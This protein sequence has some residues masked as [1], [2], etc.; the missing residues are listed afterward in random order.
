MNN[1]ILKSY[2][3]SLKI[4]KNLSSN[5]I[6]SYSI[7][8]NNFFEYVN[9]VYTKITLE[10]INNYIIHLSKKGL[11]NSSINHNITSLKMFYKYLIKEGITNTN[12]IDKVARPKKEA[13]LPDYLTIDEINMLLSFKL[14]NAYD[15]RNKALLE[16]MYATGVRVSEVINVKIS[17]IDFYED[18]IT[19]IGKGNKERIIPLTSIAL[20]SIRVYLDEYY[21]D[22]LKS[23]KSEYLFINKSGGRLTRQGVVKIINTIALKQGITKN[24]YPHIIRHS[25]ATHLLNNGASLLVIKE[26]LGHE[27]IS[28]TGIYTHLSVKDLKDNY[29]LYHPHK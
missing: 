7:D 27:N 24:I 4:E 19:V 9:K 6:S 28:T 5:T 11:N 2:L 25:F 14:E 3:T 13:K 26:L 17:D 23:N 8:L 18:Y 29:E 20:A 10:D 12:L 15:Y 1:S 21:Q 16:L 22:L